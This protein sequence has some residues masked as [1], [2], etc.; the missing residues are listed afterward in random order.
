MGTGTFLGSIL[1]GLGLLFSARVMECGTLTTTVLGLGGFVAG[2]LI[3]GYV[4]R[5]GPVYADPVLPPRYLASA[6]TP[7]RTEE[8]PVPEPILDENKIMLA[9]EQFKTTLQKVEATPI[10]NIQ[11]PKITLDAGSLV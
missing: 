3:G 11:M 8:M 9:A 2:S 4:N 7:K 5:D 6:K 10:N 1:G